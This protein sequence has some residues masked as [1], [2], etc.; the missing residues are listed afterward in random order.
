MNILPENVTASGQNQDGKP[1][2]QPLSR[3]S[4]SEGSTNQHSGYGHENEEDQ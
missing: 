3:Q 1:L 2:L 4:A